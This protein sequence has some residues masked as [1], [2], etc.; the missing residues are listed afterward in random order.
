MRVPLTEG[1]VISMF[2]NHGAI[3]H[4][5]HV[6][7]K[8]GRFGSDYVD[9]KQV[10]PHTLDFVRLAEDLA[11]RLVLLDL[12]VTVVVGPE[13]GAVVLAHDVA[14]YLS[15][16]SETEVIGLPIAKEGKDSHEFVFESGYERFITGQR[17][18]ITEDLLT[19]GGS[20]RGVISAIHANGGT[21]MAVGDLWN[22]GGVTA[23][24]L[25]VPHLVS[26]ANKLYPSYSEEENPM[27]RARVPLKLSLGHPQPYLD[28]HPDYP[29]VP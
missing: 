24:A 18:V 9:K 26:L 11:A 25:G 5:L 22:R 7:Y 4:D 23:E 15:L 16:C 20:V 19:T 17:V 21:V 28:E 13:K 14:R 12:D 27:L 10:L 6:R 3:Q 1:D 29:T 2:E 8:S